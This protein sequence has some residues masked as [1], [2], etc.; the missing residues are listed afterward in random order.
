MGEWYWCEWGSL[1]WCECY[2]CGYWVHNPGLP[3]GFNP[4]GLC[5]WC[6]DWFLAGGEPYEPC[7]RTRASNRIQL[8]F[9]DF[10]YPVCIAIACYLVPWYEP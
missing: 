3:D 9:H 4:S 5:D 10:D 7:A 6:L 2:W 1:G 8:W